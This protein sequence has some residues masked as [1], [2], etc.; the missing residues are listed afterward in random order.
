MPFYELNTMPPSPAQ[1]P[2]NTVSTGACRSLTLIENMAL[3]P[4]NKRYGLVSI[5]KLL[6]GAIVKPRVGILS[7]FLIHFQFLNGRRVPL[8]SRASICFGAYSINCQIAASTIRT[9]SIFVLARPN[10]SPSRLKG[11]RAI[12]VWQFLVD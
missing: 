3:S 2:S 7:N 8:D 10:L 12:H 4:D 1:S 11:K 5:L 6:V 9:D